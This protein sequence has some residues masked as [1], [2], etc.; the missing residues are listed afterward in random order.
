MTSFYLSCI[1][2]RD[3]FIETGFSAYSTISA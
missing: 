2:I 3:V 1:I